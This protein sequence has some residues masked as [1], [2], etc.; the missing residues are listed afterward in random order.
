MAAACASPARLRTSSSGSSACAPVTWPLPEIARAARQ[1]FLAPL[2]S[3]AMR[4]KYNRLGA[5]ALQRPASPRKPSLLR[6]IPPVH[7]L[8]TAMLFVHDVFVKN[9]AAT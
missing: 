9:S 2:P 3:A 7:Q 5:A 8:E 4:E 1:P 6:R